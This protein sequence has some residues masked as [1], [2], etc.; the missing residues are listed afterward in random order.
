MVTPPFPEYV[1]GHSTFSAAAA[2]TLRKFTGRDNFGFSVTIPVG[3]SRVEPGTVPASN[4]SLSWATFSAAAD[5]AGLSRRFGGIHF[6]DGDLEGRRVGKKIG[7][8]AYEKARDLFG[9]EDS[10]HGHEEGY[11]D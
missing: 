1:S 7:K 11:D 10:D 9:D 4:V 5:E 6:I 2:A 3:S 8:A